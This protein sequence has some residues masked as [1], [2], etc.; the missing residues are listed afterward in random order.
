MQ[1]T[2]PAAVLLHAYLLRAA[3]GIDAEL[4][5]RSLRKVQNTAYTRFEGLLATHAAPRPPSYMRTWRGRRSWRRARRR[6]GPSPQR[7]LGFCMPYGARADGFSDTGAERTLQRPHAAAEPSHWGCSAECGLLACN[8]GWKEA[9]SRFNCQH[10]SHNSIQQRQLTSAARMQSWQ[11][12]SCQ[13][14]QLSVRFAQQHSAAPADL[15]R[16]ASTPMSSS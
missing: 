15:R 6:S 16:R 2:H 14:L 4:N 9:A 11:E 8:R 13:P 1:G 3:V 5:A 7:R 10:G 12:G